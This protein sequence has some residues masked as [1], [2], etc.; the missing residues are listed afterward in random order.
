MLRLKL[1]K[2]ACPVDLRAMI[3]R[4][5]ERDKELPWSNMSIISVLS[6]M[7]QMT[8]SRF[9]VADPVAMLACYSCY[10]YTHTFSVK[11]Y[12]YMSV[13]VHSY[14]R[15][16]TCIRTYSCC[17]HEQLL[18]VGGPPHCVTIYVN[19]LCYIFSS[20]YLYLFFTKK[21]FLTILITSLQLRMKFG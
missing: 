15:T 16:C 8:H 3:T 7:D 14:I 6:S 18:S 19:G 4:S 5:R 17:L 1:A 12:F 13:S 20:F 9:I 11:I 2:N 10:S 21:L